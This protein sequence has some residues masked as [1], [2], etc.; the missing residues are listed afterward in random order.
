MVELDALE[1]LHPG[2]LAQLVRDAVMPY[3]DES[4]ANRLA[5]AR[6]AA[7]VEAEEAWEEATQ[8]ERYEMEAITAEA[9]EV[10]G[11]YRPRIEAL[12]TEMAADLAPLEERL[13]T[14]QH[15]V[16]E[17]ADDF[18]LDLPS[19]PEGVVDFPDEE[20]WLFDSDRSYLDQLGVFQNYK[21]ATSREEEAS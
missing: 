2:V 12:S 1:A 9:E 16:R 3:R 20:G 6:R 17:V 7:Q 10:V 18:D 4:L 8:D 14:L 11:R 13:E 5:R 19:R 15:A 21:Q